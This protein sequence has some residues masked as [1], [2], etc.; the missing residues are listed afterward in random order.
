MAADAFKLSLPDEILFGALQRLE[1]MGAAQPSSPVDFDENEFANVRRTL[2]STDYECQGRLILCRWDWA[3]RYHLESQMFDVM[4][5]NL[6]VNGPPTEAEM[7]WFGEGLSDFWNLT[8]SFPVDRLRRSMELLAIMLLGRHLGSNMIRFNFV[9]VDDQ[10]FAEHINEILGRTRDGNLLP[11]HVEIDIVE[12]LLDSDTLATCPQPSNGHF[13]IHS[14]TQAR[15]MALRVQNHLQPARAK[16]LSKLLGTCAHE[17]LHALFRIYDCDCDACL[18]RGGNTCS[19]GGYNSTW[20]CLAYRLKCYMETRLGI[21]TN[22][23]GEIEMASHI[24]DTGEWEILALASDFGL[25]RGIV[26]LEYGHL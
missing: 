14:D 1:D 17:M 11:Y 19:K 25:D 3:P 13:S 23:G 2:V 6:L 5:H 10:D 26:L 21:A 12:Q 18:A 16:T 4:Y 20:L 24:A 8:E 15:T 9:G 7:I 22:L